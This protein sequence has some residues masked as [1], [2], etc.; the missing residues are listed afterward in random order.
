M[1]AM[2]EDAAGAD[3]LQPVET[4]G[5]P[6]LGVDGGEG[7][8]V[9]EL[10]D[11]RAQQVAHRVLVGRVG[12]IDLDLPWDVHRERGDPVRDLEGGDRRL[13][14]IEDLA[15]QFGEGPG[16]F[17]RGGEFEDGRDRR[18]QEAFAHAVA[19]AGAPAAVI[20]NG[21]SRRC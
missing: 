3:G 7:R 10:A 14:G 18:W 15:Q 13:G 12:E 2:D 21:R 11:D 8:V 17:A 16:L 9:D 20:G 1:R 19:L 5:D 4:V 6:V